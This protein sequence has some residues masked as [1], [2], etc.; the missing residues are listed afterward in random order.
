MEKILMD[1]D[2]TYMVH[3]QT[4]NQTQLVSR[5]VTLETVFLGCMVKSPS[6]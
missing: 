5:S 6:F 3:V 4:R 1:L 2:P